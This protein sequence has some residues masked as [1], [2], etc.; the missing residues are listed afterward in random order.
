MPKYHKVQSLQNVCTNGLY[1]VLKLR[2]KIYKKSTKGIETTQK[3]FSFEK[4]IGKF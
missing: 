4:F 2:K 3:K 1:K